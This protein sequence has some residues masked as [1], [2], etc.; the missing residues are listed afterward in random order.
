[1]PGI[2]GIVL[3][4]AAERRRRAMMFECGERKDGLMVLALHTSVTCLED[5]SLS[6]AARSSPVFGRWSTPDFA[7]DGRAGRR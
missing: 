7:A 1:M 5:L 3:V 2:V 4:P 6:S